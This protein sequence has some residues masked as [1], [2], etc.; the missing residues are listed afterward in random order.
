MSQ[1]Q[2][3]Q[4]LFIFCYNIIPGTYTHP[5]CGA[6]LF[7]FRHLVLLT[8]ADDVQQTTDMPNHFSNIKRMIDLKSSKTCDTISVNCFKKISACVKRK[9]Q[10]MAG[11][12]NSTKITQLHQ[13]VI[14]NPTN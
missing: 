8:G 5:Y 1:Q 12:F 14:H 13:T 10:I 6:G 4:Q 3:F 2:L 11:N 7:S 9:A